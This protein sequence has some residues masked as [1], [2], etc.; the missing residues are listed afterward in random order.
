MLQVRISLQNNNTPSR[1][2][3]EGFLLMPYTVKNVIIVLIGTATIILLI[4]IIYIKE[5]NFMKDSIRISCK[6]TLTRFCVFLIT[7]LMASTLVCTVCA[8]NI[9]VLKNVDIR[10]GDTIGLLFHTSIPFDS[11]VGTVKASINNRDIDTK[12]H[13]T[14]YNNDNCCT[15]LVTGIYPH[16][17]SEKIT[18]SLSGLNLQFQTS[19]KEELKK[20]LNNS[21][22]E[23]EKLF[24]SDLL[25]YGEA[26]WQYREH[27]N[28]TNQPCD[29]TTNVDGYAPSSDS[30]STSLIN[31]G[32]STSVVHISS[33]GI[34]Y[35]DTNHYVIEVEVPQAMQAGAKID[36]VFKRHGEV[37]EEK[38][39]THEGG[40]Q[41]YSFT[42][43]ALEAHKIATESLGVELQVNDT[44][45]QTIDNYGLN[46]FI[47]QLSEVGATSDQGTALQ[48]AKALYYYGK[49]AEKVYN[50]KRVF[51]QYID[52]SAMQN[53]R[54]INDGGKIVF[55]CDNAK[56]HVYYYD[57]TEADIT[58]IAWAVQNTPTDYHNFY[59]IAVTGTAKIPSTDQTVVATIQKIR[60]EN[61]VTFKPSSTIF[62]ETHN[63]GT[64][65]LPAGKGEVIPAIGLP[66]QVEWAEN[67]LSTTLEA[68]DAK[69][70]TGMKALTLSHTFIDKN[71]EEVVVDVPFVYCNTIKS[72]EVLSAHEIKDEYSYGPS[73]NANWYK[74]DN[75]T[76]ISL[77]PSQ[78]TVVFDNDAYQSY[79]IA[80]D[81]WEV[82]AT[83]QEEVAYASSISAESP[84]Y[85]FSVDTI[86][87]SKVFAMVYGD[88]V[89]GG[90]P[91]RFDENVCSI[92]GKTQ[93]MNRVVSIAIYE[94]TMTYTSTSSCNIKIQFALILESGEKLEYDVQT[95]KEIHATMTGEVYV[96]PAKSSDKV[97]WSLDTKKM[98]LRI[99][100][101]D[102]VRRDVQESSEITPVDPIVAVQPEPLKQTINVFAEN[103][104]TT[105]ISVTLRVKITR[106]S[107]AHELTDWTTQVDNI[108]DEADKKIEN[109]KFQNGTCS[110]TAP[111][112]IWNPIISFNGS[113]NVDAIDSAEAHILMSNKE[114]N[115]TRQNG[116]TSTIKLNDIKVPNIQDETLSAERFISYDEYQGEC[117]LTAYKVPR[118]TVIV[119]NSVVEITPVKNPTDITF[120]K[121]QSAY[122]IPVYLVC[123]NGQ[124]SG[125]AT[126]TVT[127]NAVIS[128]LTNA[129]WKNNTAQCTTTCSYNS[130]STDVTLSVTR[131]G[132]TIGSVEYAPKIV[133]LPSSADGTVVTV[134]FK[135]YYDGSSPVDCEKTFRIYSSGTTTPGTPTTSTGGSARVELSYGGVTENYDISWENP[136]KSIEIT[137]N[138]TVKFTGGNSTTTPTG[139]NIKVTYTNGAT[140]TKSSN[141]FDWSQVTYTGTE[142][143]TTV[144]VTATY[145]GKSASKSGVTAANPIESFAT[146]EQPTQFNGATTLS[147]QSTV[148]ATLGNG[149]TCSAVATL[150]LVNATDAQGKNLEHGLKIADNKSITYGGTRSEIK[151]TIQY[152]CADITQTAVHTIDNGQ[153]DPNSGTGINCITFTAQHYTVPNIQ[154][155][156]S[157][158]KFNSLGIKLK[159]GVELTLTN[160]FAVSPKEGKSEPTT[161]SY[162]RGLSQDIK[163]ITDETTQANGT[164]KHIWLMGTSGSKQVIV[165]VGTIVSNRQ[166]E[167]QYYYAPHYFELAEHIT[168]DDEFVPAFNK[169]KVYSELYPAYTNGYDGYTL[170]A[171]LEMGY[172][173]DDQLCGSAGLDW[174]ARFVIFNESMSNVSEKLGYPV[175]TKFIY[176]YELEVL[177]SVIEVGGVDD[178]RAFRYFLTQPDGYPKHLFGFYIPVSSQKIYFDKTHINITDATA[179]I[180]PKCRYE[181]KDGYA[182]YYTCFA[183]PGMIKTP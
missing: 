62:V 36:I 124:Q 81:E 54:F 181:N 90:I 51:A 133:Q 152:T 5:D 48:Y 172:G 72:I 73:V 113:F 86:L 27:V 151:I 88:L 165:R 80:K 158:M 134:K 171:T 64:L 93:I 9:P 169:M 65:T 21:A 83:I 115:V 135:V 128:A 39:Q 140:Q 97:S 44:P 125:S 20:M 82:Y 60:V 104:D 179:I 26:T 4:L 67:A 105:K 38:T 11:N 10:L 121:N 1:V 57:G 110:V 61:T 50:D 63:N 98:E 3:R 160:V 85:E 118:I 74:S 8:D 71:N 114:I 91:D 42:S 106:A 28:G 17:I 99:Q 108:R 53:P 32:N 116:Y 175:G 55:K 13:V 66:F 168:D 2:L 122:E 69:T 163:N 123:K 84:Y 156:D 155:K 14:K 139:G 43:P 96:L 119:S 157:E 167:N 49:S 12:Q 92:S 117:H 102:G 176:P 173:T 166:I 16:E 79:D 137:T 126:A 149:Q 130:L 120:N 109:V 161:T 58:D 174:Q 89:T 103:K 24:A 162:D 77:Q 37:L 132:G 178:T 131:T 164:N 6:R 15:F 7:I 41:K 35:S 31:I 180:S 111:V 112:V 143:Q 136:V 52:T 68:A 138:P 23:D 94:A 141:E 70:A 144:K 100:G 34:A 18:L 95:N 40:T 46:N 145:K 22:S 142:T 25:Q 75:G 146:P 127:H 59:D 154:N 150:S 129:T 177:K 159:N 87:P 30:I 33:I 107:G 56:M 148:Q 29:I 19:V 182:M 78:I 183:R 170:S 101:S 153:Q 76:F 147:L 45:V 47:A